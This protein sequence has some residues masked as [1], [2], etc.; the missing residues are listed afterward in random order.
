MND[1]LCHSPLDICSYNFEENICGSLKRLCC[2]CYVAPIKMTS[3]SRAVISTC[4]GR[5]AGTSV[6]SYHIVTYINHSIDSCPIL[7]GS[8]TAV[9]LLPF[10]RPVDFVSFSALSIRS[11]YI[12]EMI[13]EHEHNSSNSNI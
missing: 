6:V 4:Q 9:E 2:P 3:P 12:V 5:L 11:A 13:T 10:I 8:S 1:N 7:A